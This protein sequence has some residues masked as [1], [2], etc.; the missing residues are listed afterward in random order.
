MLNV[1]VAIS[2]ASSLMV[3]TVPACSLLRLLG[4]TLN[5]VSQIL[6]VECIYVIIAVCVCV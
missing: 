6:K 4:R 5:N 2:N 1:R 3:V